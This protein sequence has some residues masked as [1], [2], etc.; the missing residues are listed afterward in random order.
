M[1]FCGILSSIEVGWWGLFSFHADESPG[2]CICVGEFI[3]NISYGM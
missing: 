3:L 1:T 2:S